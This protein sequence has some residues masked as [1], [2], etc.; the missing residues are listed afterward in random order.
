MKINSDQIFVI[1]IIVI[2]LILWIGFSVYEILYEYKKDLKFKRIFISSKKNPNYCCVVN[3]KHSIINLENKQLILV[4]SEFFNTDIKLNMKNLQKN[5]IS[6]IRNKNQLSI[7]TK[8]YNYK[9]K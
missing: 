3:C 6:F 2:F 5:K 9:N 7:S 8:H 1:C 4:Y